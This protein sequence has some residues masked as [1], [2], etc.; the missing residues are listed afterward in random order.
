MVPQVLNATCN[1]LT[2]RSILRLRLAALLTALVACAGLLSLGSAPAWAAAGTITEFP[3]TGASF[4]IAAGP[5][6]NLWYTEVSGKN[7]GRITTS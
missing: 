1:L 3:A 4:G 5:D 2:Y 6:G 7:I